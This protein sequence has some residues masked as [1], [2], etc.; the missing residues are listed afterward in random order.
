MIR[1]GAVIIATG[2]CAFLSKALGCNVLTG[3]GYLIASEA[4]ANLSGMAFSNAHAISPVFSSVTKTAFY[5][6]VTFYDGNGSVIEGAGSQ[7]G[8]SLIAKTLQPQRVYA[9]LDKADEQVQKWMHQAQPNFFLL[10]DR[11][12]INPFTDRFPITMRLAGT[13]RGTG[14]INLISEKCETRIP[15]LYAAGDPATRELICGDLQVVEAI[16]PHGQCLP[17]RGQEKQPGVLL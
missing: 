15:G 5:T 3:D 13:V 2:G 17:A 9:M 10:F 14:G 12:G 1:A 4:G 16:M 6:W 11:L 7:K 8:R